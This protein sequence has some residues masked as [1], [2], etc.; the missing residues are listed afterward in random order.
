MNSVTM[1]SFADE[2]RKIAAGNVVNPMKPIVGGMG[3]NIIGKPLPSPGIGKGMSAAKPQPAKSTNYSMV[4]S[5][6]PMAAFS[7]GSST[8]M[9]PPPPVKT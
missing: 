2:L 4:H 6:P 7:A 5:T 9:A 3:S 1:A 8:K